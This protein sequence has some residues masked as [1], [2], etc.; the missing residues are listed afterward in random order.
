MEGLGVP[1]TRLCVGLLTPV[2]V[3]PAAG[4]GLPSA[5]GTMRFHGKEKKKNGR[6]LWINVGNQLL[7]GKEN[8]F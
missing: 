1:G 8:A 3:A 6:R 5:G 2:L 4:W 7:S